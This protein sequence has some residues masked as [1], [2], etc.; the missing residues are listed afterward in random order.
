[1]KSCREGLVVEEKMKSCR[2]EDEVVEAL[3]KRRVFRSDYVQLS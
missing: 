3:W 1:M 2:G